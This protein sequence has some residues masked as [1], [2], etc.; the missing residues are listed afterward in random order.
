MGAALCLRPVGGYLAV[1]RAERKHRVCALFICGAGRIRQMNQSV[2]VKNLTFLL[3][4]PKKKLWASAA[5]I[6]SF[7][8][9]AYTL[10]KGVKDWLTVSPSLGISVCL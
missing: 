9:A 6:F 5:S 4:L 7:R 8:Y 2:S 1:P 10:G 3:S